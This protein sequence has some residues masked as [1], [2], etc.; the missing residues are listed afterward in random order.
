MECRI[1]PYMTADGP[2]NMAWDEALLNAAVAD[3]STAWLRVYGWS[4]PWL[5]LGYFQEIARRD[6]DPRW[7]DAPTVRRMTGGGALWHD[8]ELTY[9]V[10]LPAG[11]PYVK[12]STLAY[13]A[14]H[15]AIGDL[16]VQRGLPARRRCRDAGDEPPMMMK[17]KEADSK[18]KRT[19]ERPFLCFLDHDPNDLVARGVKVLGSAQRRRDRTLIQ[20]GGLLLRASPRAPELLGVADLA[21][22]EVEAG[23]ADAPELW[24][25]SV[26][27]AI[28]HALGLTGVAV[29][30]SA[31]EP[32]PSLLS[33][34][35]A[36][37]VAEWD[38]FRD[39]NWT[40]RR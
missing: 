7:R 11:H 18:P 30:R 1:V 6:G 38:I 19:A 32:S 15:D 13:E 31:S 10:V 24:V 16:L 23:V 4:D 37:R 3:P 22:A 20:H 17:D 26:R 9:A 28:L 34:N 14:V 35:E 27:D 12:R 5:S 2:T 40:R 21:E 29:G 8:R 39:P 36:A 33:L 25:E